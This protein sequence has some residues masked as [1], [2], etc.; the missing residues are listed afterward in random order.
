M[1]SGFCGHSHSISFIFRSQGA[2]ELLHRNSLVH[3]CGLTQVSIQV[4]E[5][6][7]SHVST[8]EIAEIHLRLANISSSL[9][10]N[11]ME[12]DEIQVR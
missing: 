10:D 7:K 2:L 3:I 11:N 9:H 8:A 4:E 6:M 12:D 5:G 1:I